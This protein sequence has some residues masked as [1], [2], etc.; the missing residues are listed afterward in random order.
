[1]GCSS[2][3][4]LLRLSCLVLF[5]LSDSDAASS[6]VRLVCG[7]TACH[8]GKGLEKEGRTLQFATDKDLPLVTALKQ[9]PSFPSRCSAAAAAGSAWLVQNQEWLSSA[10]SG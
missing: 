9:D 1:M 8:L 7:L 5:P 4:G 10:G 6:G 3:A 2:G